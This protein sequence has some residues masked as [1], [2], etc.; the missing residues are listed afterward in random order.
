MHVFYSCVSITFLL[1]EL[2]NKDSVIRFSV[3]REVLN[4][5]YK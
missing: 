3:Q 2:S 1:L 5:A 4:D